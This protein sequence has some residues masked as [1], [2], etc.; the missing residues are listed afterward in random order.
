MSR[1]VAGVDEAGRGPLAG[2][3]AVAAVVLDPA[4]DWSDVDDSKKL[5]DQQRDQL[6]DF[7][8]RNALA[9]HIELVDVAT[10][11]RVNIFHAT[12]HGMQQVVARLPNAPHEVLVDGNKAPDFGAGIV[13]TP[14]VGGDASEKCI[15]AASIIAKQARDAYMV[16]LDEQHP[17]YGFARH[18]GY[19]TPEHLAVLREL[20]PSPEHRRSFAP[21]QAQLQG[22]LFA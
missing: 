6:S 5:S 1:L 13:A 17:G 2:P 8:K 15:G 9:W 12:M 16:A 18:K 7:I 10:I 3:V 21:V 14:I 4:V 22:Q 11:D 20:G 19:P